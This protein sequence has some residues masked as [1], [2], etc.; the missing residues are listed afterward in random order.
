MG[1][2]A[3]TAKYLIGARSKPLNRQC[4]GNYVDKQMK[5]EEG[6][7]DRTLASIV[8]AK[9]RSAP[10]S[11]SLVSNREGKQADMYMHTL[12]EDILGCVHTQAADRQGA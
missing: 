10:I 7:R 11:C 12:R 3:K 5:Y 2:N 1:S 9:A 8:P 6:K 4:K